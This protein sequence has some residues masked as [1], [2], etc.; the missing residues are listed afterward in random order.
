MMNLIPRTTV[1]KD[2]VIDWLND[3]SE[4]AEIGI[5]VG[6]FGQ[7]DLVAFL[8]D[9]ETGRWILALDAITLPADKSLLDQRRKRLIERLREIHAEG[10]ETE[11]GAMIVTMEGV[12]SRTLNLFSLNFEDAFTFKDTEQAKGFADEFFDVLHHALIPTC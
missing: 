7:R 4:E 12:L 8:K 10:G 9:G 5:D 6:Q 2:V 1:K 11:H 3:V